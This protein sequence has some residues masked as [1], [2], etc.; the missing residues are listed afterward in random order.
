M[1]VRRGAKKIR[2]QGKR[3]NNSKFIKPK[4][5]MHSVVQPLWEGKKSVRQ[6]LQTLGV[7]ENPN[8]VVAKAS[9]A[10]TSTTTPTTDTEALFSLPPVEQRDRNPRRRLM[11]EEDQ[12]YIVKLIAVYGEDFK[13]HFW[14]G[15]GVGSR[16]WVEE[17]CMCVS[18]MICNEM[19][20]G[21]SFSFCPAQSLWF[22]PFPSPLCSLSINQTTPAP[23]LAESCL[24]KPHRHGTQ[25]GGA[26]PMYSR[27]SLLAIPG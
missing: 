4:A 25:I 17:S 14:V 18:L 15:F 1:K 5:G 23:L 21:Y 12:S 13:V 6:N 2:L 11:S 22:S 19:S 9:S 20:H 3:Q 7:S 26:T 10:S 24:N 27:T 8:R 16:G